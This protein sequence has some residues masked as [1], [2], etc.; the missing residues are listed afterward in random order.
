MACCA[1]ALF[2]L[3]QIATGLLALRRAVP[4]GLLGRP[5]AAPRPNPATAWQ[6]AAESPLPRTRAGATRLAWRAPGRA[7][8][9]VALLE[10]ALVG[11][12]AIW[13]LHG[14]HASAHALES[15]DENTLWCG[16][17]LP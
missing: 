11:A 8:A 17:I 14:T 10:L 7:F 1:F 12:A 2:V 4:F 15:L 9:V 16:R 6:L 3:G 13:G 5:S